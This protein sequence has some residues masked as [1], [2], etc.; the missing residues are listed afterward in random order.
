MNT[1][2]TSLPVGLPD[3]ACPS[4]RRRARPGLSSTI[5]NVVLYQI[6]WFGCVLAAASGRPILAMLVAL[7]SAAFHLALANNRRLEASVLLVSGLTGLVVDTATVQLGILSFPAQLGPAGMAPL[8]IVALWMQ[9]GMTLRFCF[10]W[11]SGRY[12]LAS[13]LGFFG[14][15]LSFLAGARLGAVEVGEPFVVSLLLLGALWS[16]ALPL[17]VAT[18]DFA[19]QRGSGVAVSKGH[20]IFD[21]HPRAA[22][23]WSMVNPEN[24]R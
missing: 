6:G 21:F 23:E 19:G 2:G 12:L 15:P 3:V 13:V 17:L 8:W 20:Y 9:F 7:A 14:G 1:L 22:D 24:T 11:L 10:S 5:A 18:A 4:T 16:A